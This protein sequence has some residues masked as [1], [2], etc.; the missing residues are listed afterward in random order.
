M[1]K[2]YI[3]ES[4][5]IPQRSYVG[6]FSVIEKNAHMQKAYEFPGYKKGSFPVSESLQEEVLS[7]PV[8]PEISDNYVSKITE[9]INKFYK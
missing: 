1:K 6:F 2:N 3:D 5:N 7:L 9:L 8:F 4:V